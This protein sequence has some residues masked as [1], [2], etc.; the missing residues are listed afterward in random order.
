[1]NKN[2]MSGDDGRGE[3]ANNREAPATK[4]QAA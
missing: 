2:R 3:R 1:M 4:G